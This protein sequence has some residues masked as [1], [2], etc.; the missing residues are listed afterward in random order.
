MRCYANVSRHLIAQH[1][2]PRSADDLIHN[3]IRSDIEISLKK[4]NEG[5]SGDNP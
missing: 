5:G 2:T 4:R 1:D 3:V